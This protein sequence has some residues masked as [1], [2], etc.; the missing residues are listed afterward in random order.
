[1]IAKETV[2]IFT[3]YYT[4]CVILQMKQIKISDRSA[5]PGLM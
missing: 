5:N 4:D 3:V 1:M 2:P